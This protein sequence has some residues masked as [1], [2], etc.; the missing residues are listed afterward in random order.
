MSNQPEQAPQLNTEENLYRLQALFFRDDTEKRP[1]VL[2]EVTEKRPV[3]L[4][5][6]T[7]K[8]PV[9]KVLL[10][11][12][13]KRPNDS[14]KQRAEQ[15][16]SLRFNPIWIKRVKAQQEE[17]EALSLLFKPIRLQRFAS[18]EPDEMGS[19]PGSQARESKT[20]NNGDLGIDERDT[21]IKGISKQ[22]GQT[23]TT[24]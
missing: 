4:D 2:N 24:M 14:F 17:E 15:S 12:E 10:P 19:V 7:E 18:R 16:A 20:I 9:L 1:V 6:V 21:L 11:K 8:R 22:Q 13:M 3:V 23:T 5:E